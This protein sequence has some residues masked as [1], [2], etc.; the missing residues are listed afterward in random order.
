MPFVCLAGAAAAASAAVAAA[1]APG[2][3]YERRAPTQ[4]LKETQKQSEKK[5]VAYR[6]AQRCSFYGWLANGV[7]GRLLQPGTHSSPGCALFEC[8]CKKQKE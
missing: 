1:A 8:R 3:K 2:R 6:T 4:T 7:P 5:T